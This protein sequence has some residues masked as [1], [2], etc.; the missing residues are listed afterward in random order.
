M[1]NG[2]IKSFIEFG[3]MPLELTYI[4]PTM[5][6]RSD[7][8]DDEKRKYNLGEWCGAIYGFAIGGA[9]HLGQ[10]TAYTIAIMNLSSDNHINF[11]FTSQEVPSEILFV[12]FVTNILSTA[13]EV[14]REKIK[15]KRNLE[16]KVG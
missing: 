8:R 6:R 10:V 2:F 15:S 14:I 16:K 4:L 7:E 13:Y 9:I 3:T 11:P 12:P 1:K 5:Y